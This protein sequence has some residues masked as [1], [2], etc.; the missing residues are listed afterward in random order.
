MWRNSSGHNANMLNSSYRQIGIARKYVSTSTYKWYWV[1]DFSTTNDGTNAGGGY[2]GGGTQPT[3]TPQQASPTA[4]PRPATPTPAPTATK[5]TMTSPANG[6]T[7][8]TSQTFR[9]TTATGAQ[10]YFFY[11]GTT[12]GSNNL[13][14][15]STGTSTQITI[16]NLPRTG[17]TVYVRLW[18]RTSSGWLYN[19]Y[20]YRLP[21]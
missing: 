19:D 4:T 10:Q 7:L 18:T 16:N 3:P 8:S 2:G 12:L 14:G 6:A 20:T 13:V 21:N 1:T 11:M 15:T 9:W 17:Q 5:A